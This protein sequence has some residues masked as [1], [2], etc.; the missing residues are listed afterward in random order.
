[1]VL[2]NITQREINAKSLWVKLSV[3][4][5]A[6]ISYANAEEKATT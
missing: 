3:M 4:Y 5:V 2:L 1:M 6:H